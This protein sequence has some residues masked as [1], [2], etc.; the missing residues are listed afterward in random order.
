MSSREKN[1]VDAALNV[2]SRYGVKRA[3]MNDIASEAGIAR[4]TLYNAFANKEEVLRATI[5][6]H[7]ESSFAAI[8]TDC[9][10]TDDLSR[11]LDA[12]F[13]HLVVEPYER[14]VVAPHAEDLIYGFNHAAKQEIEAS[15]A[16]YRSV[17]TTV[18]APYQS[19]LEENGLTAE[20]LADCVQHACVGLKYKAR[21]KKH[22]MSLWRSLKSLA[23]MA[24]GQN[25]SR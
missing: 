8:E 22:L 24:A 9:A 5:R 7:A 25:E 15:Y 11:R 20:A 17:L 19:A 10:E 13:Q 1:I 23:L 4:Q 3:T 16:Q 18:F 12:V 21:D 2:F 6:L 14:I